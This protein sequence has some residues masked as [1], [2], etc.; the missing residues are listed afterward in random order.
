[1]I[2][3]SL[4]SL[5]SFNNVSPGKPEISKFSL[6]RYV[7]TWCSLLN[8]NILPTSNQKHSISLLLP[9]SSEICFTLD[10]LSSLCSFWIK[11]KKS[12][13]FFPHDFQSEIEYLKIIFVLDNSLHLHNI[14][15]YY[16]HNVGMRSSLSILY[17]NY[18]IFVDHQ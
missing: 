13:T 2:G 3:F 14:F 18:L 6:L 1:M 10:I 4:T 16:K 5:Y 12:Y 9:F 8:S 7:I 15:F 17:I 11:N